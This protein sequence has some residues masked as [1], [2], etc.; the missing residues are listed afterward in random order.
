M[1]SLK[2]TFEGL[3]DM[4]LGMPLATRVISGALAI[5]V[6]LG[7]WMVARWELSYLP[8]TKRSNKASTKRWEAAC[9]AVWTPRQDWR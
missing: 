2:E 4:F 3:R 7:L 8:S 5:L 6:G 1:G 9:S